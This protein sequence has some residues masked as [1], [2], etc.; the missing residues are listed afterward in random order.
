[1]VGVFVSLLVSLFAGVESE[2]FPESPD[3][4]FAAFL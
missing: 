2:D 3:S 4:A 1:L